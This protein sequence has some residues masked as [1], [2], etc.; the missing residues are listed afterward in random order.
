M[1]RKKG[2]VPS[3][4]QDSQRPPLPFELQIKGGLGGQTFAPGRLHSGCCGQKSPPSQERQDEKVHLWEGLLEGHRT[5]EEDEGPCPW[6]WNQ[7]AWGHILLCPF[8]AAQ[9]QAAL[10][11]PVS[12][13][14]S[15]VKW[16]TIGGR[17]ALMV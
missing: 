5:Q 16:E 12:S 10:V 4:G 6:L 7:A 9:P 11:T 15:S 2:F 13:A 8:L 3:P 17:L 1:G 14:S